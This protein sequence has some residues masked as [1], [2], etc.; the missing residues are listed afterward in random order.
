M[1]VLVGEEV[2]VWVGL[3]VCVADGAA[4]I[5][6]VDDGIGCG[7]RLPLQAEP[8]IA[9]PM[10]NGAIILFLFNKDHPPRRA[11]FHPILGLLIIFSYS[12]PKIKSG[13]AGPSE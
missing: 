4:F 11:F 12:Y 2:D 13:S 3:W 8:R 7:K 6:S 1:N 9:M 10:T 5:L